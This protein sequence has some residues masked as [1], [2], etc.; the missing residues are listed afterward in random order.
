MTAGSPGRGSRVEESPPIPTPTRPLVMVEG[1]WRLASPR[2][3]VSVC[4]CVGGV[5]VEVGVGIGKLG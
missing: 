5:E 4:R 1:Q 3:S 2:V